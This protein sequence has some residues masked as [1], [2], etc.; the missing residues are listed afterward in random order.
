MRR[1]QV[2]ISYSL[3]TDRDGPLSECRF[4]SYSNG[5]FQII[6]GDLSW[7][8]LFWRDIT[9]CWSKRI[10]DAMFRIVW[11]KHNLIN[12]FR[13]DCAESKEKGHLS[14]RQYQTEGIGSIAQM[15]LE[16]YNW[17]LPAKFRIEDWYDISEFTNQQNFGLYASHAEGA[18][19]EFV[20]PAER[21][22]DIL[23]WRKKR[24]SPT[25]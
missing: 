19:L 21:L 6:R 22:L 8:F 7:T 11:M 2:V 16:Q 3:R 1:Y 23:G 25:W 15:L 18:T 20:G 24:I 13:E 5:D 9:F 17:I 12:I 10:W 14:C 4:T